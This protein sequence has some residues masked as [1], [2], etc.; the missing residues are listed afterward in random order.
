MKSI[1][2]NAEHCPR[3]G[4]GHSALEFKK[5]KKASEQ[6]THWAMC[7]ATQEPMFLSGV[8]EEKTAGENINAKMPAIG[9]GAPP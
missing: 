4:N 7:P 2:I 8:A 5:L 1:M 3:C 6:Y 9:A